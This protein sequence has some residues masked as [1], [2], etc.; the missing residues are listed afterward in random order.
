MLMIST[1]NFAASCNAS[2]DFPL[3]VGPSNAYAAVFCTT[4]T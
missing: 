4:A 2:R 3:A 1:G